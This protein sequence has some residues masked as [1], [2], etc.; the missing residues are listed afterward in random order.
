MPPATAAGHVQFGV[1]LLYRRS[2]M[3]HYYLVPTT[4]SLNARSFA[5][6]FVNNVVR[7]QGLP[8]TLISSDR[9]P[10]LHKRKRKEERSI[11]T[12]SMD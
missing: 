12:T 3:V 5:A 9:G 2:K 6:L 1:R 8:A 4:E 7:T 10:Q 11:N